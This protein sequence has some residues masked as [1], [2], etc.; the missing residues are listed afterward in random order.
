MKRLNLT[1]N[2]EHV[3]SPLEADVLKVLWPNKKLKV[4]QIFEI[5][6]SQRKVALTSVAVILDRLYEKNIVDREVETGRGGLRYLY[7]PKKNKKQFEKSIVEGAVNKLIDK[8]GKT[9]IN[10]FNERFPKG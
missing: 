9:A 10:Y 7:F 3:L 1:T 6:K 8:F 4:R 2:F 5:L